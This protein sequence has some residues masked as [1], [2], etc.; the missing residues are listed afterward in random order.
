MAAL[1][2]GTTCE[3]IRGEW[4]FIIPPPNMVRETLVDLNIR[5]AEI[6]AARLGEKPS[7]TSLFRWRTDGYPICRHGPKVRMPCVVGIKKVKASVE[8]LQRFLIAVEVLS[9]QIAAAGGVEK[10]EERYGKRYI[11]SI[12]A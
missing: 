6:L 10:W 12:G 8:S 4:V 11:S 7:R 1:P 3:R 2:A 9:A 5:G